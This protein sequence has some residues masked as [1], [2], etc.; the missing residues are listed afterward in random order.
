M[1]AC[2]SF[3]VLLIVGF[4]RFG[5][6]IG[7][8]CSRTVHTYNMQNLITFGGLLVQFCFFIFE[9]TSSLPQHA[10]QLLQSKSGQ[11]LHAHQLFQ[12]HLCSD[13]LLTSG[14]YS[15]RLSSQVFEVRQLQV[16]NGIAGLI[17]R[18]RQGLSFLT[19]LTFCFLVGICNK[20]K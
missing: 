15:Q 1:G 5:L 8:R 19:R 11:P 9:I 17:L 2:I 3:L 14:C 10:R 6:G 12:I 4:V 16:F 20:K 7:S 18:R 13:Q